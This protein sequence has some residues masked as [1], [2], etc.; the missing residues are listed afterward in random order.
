[1][2]G[3]KTPEVVE[4]ML[5][6]AGFDKVDIVLKEQSREVIKEWIPGSGAED[7]IV[8]ANITAWKATGDVKS[9]AAAQATQS[10]C[11]PA[12]TQTSQSCCPPP[13]P[14]ATVD[15]QTGVEP[16]AAGCDTGS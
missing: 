4:Q 11:A 13:A 9:T 1:M 10:C 3:A 14:A 7:Y 5:L 15:K 12:P 2:S 16:K 8:S 6:A